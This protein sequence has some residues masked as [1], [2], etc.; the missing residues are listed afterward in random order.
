MKH[1]FR[2]FLRA[3]RDSLTREEVAEKSARIT[4]ALISSDLFEKSGS[5]FVYLDVGN[6]VCTRPLIEHCF[7]IG[8]P[9]FVPVTKDGGMFFSEIRDFSNFVPA[10]FGIPEPANPILAE[11]D[12]NSLFVIPGVG[13]DKNGNRVGYGAGFYDKYLHCRSFMHLVGVCF[14]IQIA[15]ELP[16]EETDVSMDSV[17]TE[18]EWIIVEKE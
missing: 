1:H 11:P 3:H 10:A 12:E 17:L 5:L 15:D 4:E 7:R 6:E 16:A 18:T 14:E 9:V 13:F 8:K 2:Q